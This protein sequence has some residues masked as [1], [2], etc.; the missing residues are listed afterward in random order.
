MTQASKQNSNGSA[1]IVFLVAPAGTGKTFSGDYLDV[2]HGFKHVDGDTPIKNQHLSKEYKVIVTN[3]IKV[4]LEYNPK[5]EDGPDEVWKPYFEELAKLTLDAA[6][7]S[8][9]VVLTFAAYRQTYRDF[10]FEKLVEGGASKDSLT[11][12]VLTID[13]DVKLRSLYYRSKHLAEAGGMTL[14]ELMKASGWK[15]DGEVTCSRYIEICKAGYAGFFPQFTFQEGP[16][17]SKIVDVSGRD[18]SHLDGLDEALGLVGK[19]LHG[20]LTFEEIRDKV[21]PIDA[22]REKDWAANVDMAELSALVADSTDDNANANANIATKVVEE[23]RKKI[24]KRRSSLMQIELEGL[25]LYSSSE[26]DNSAE[27]KARRESFIMTGTIE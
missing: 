11:L 26:N 3:I 23:E 16:S 13:L 12:V 18:M 17:G 27:M 10:L 2:F 19:R 6:K 15:G 25:R 7:H 24:A 1:E 5:G 8:D 14:E 9:K 21:K 4:L 20:D 22:Q